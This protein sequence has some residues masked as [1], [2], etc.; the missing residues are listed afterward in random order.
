MKAQEKAHA[1]DSERVAAL[2][3][4]VRTTARTGGREWNG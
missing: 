4:R 1:R 3:N 2:M